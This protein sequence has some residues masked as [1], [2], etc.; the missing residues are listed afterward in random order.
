MI[1]VADTSPLNYL[2][3]I[4]E[5]EIL[6][7]I[8]KSVAIPIDVH[9][10]L[11]SPRGPAPVR[12]WASA[13]P[14]WCSVHIPTSLPNALLDELDTGERS[15]IQLALD[16]GIDTILVD[17]GEGRRAALL[18]KLAVAGTVGVLEKAAQLGLINFRSALERLEKTNFRLSSSLHKQF[19]ERNP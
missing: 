4:G 16:R 19:L 15:A 18:C 14:L 11:L 17:D 12:E 7:A 3:L 13:L 5:I 10:E 1:V 9:H 6:P 8:Y 2:I